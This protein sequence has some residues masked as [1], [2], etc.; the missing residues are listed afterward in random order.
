MLADIFMLMTIFIYKKVCRYSQT[1][2]HKQCSNHLPVL[3]HSMP[4]TKLARPIQ[5]YQMTTNEEQ[6]VDNGGQVECSCSQFQRT[7]T[8]L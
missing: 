2:C 1:M 4:H 7:S 8:R 6:S 3:R 5:R